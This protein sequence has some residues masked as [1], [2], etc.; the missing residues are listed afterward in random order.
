MTGGLAL[1]LL[2]LAACQATSA[3]HDAKTTVSTAL[4]ITPTPTAQ[5][6]RSASPHTTVGTTPSAGTTVTTV[7]SRNHV[8]AGSSP[9]FASITYT[10]S[11]PYEQAVSLLQAVGQTPYPWTCDDPLTPT[12]PSIEQQ[13]AAYAA[14]HQL[15]ISYPRDDQLTQLAASPQVRSVDVATLYMCP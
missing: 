1:T 9:L 12:P 14:S 15:L 13:G 11:T 4:Q 5:V 8:S 6:T 2:A 3:R 7:S 10:T